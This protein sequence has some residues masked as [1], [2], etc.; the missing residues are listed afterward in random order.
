[1]L[2]WIVA[3]T[4]TFLFQVSNVYVA[5]IVFVLWIIMRLF[6]R[7]TSYSFNQKE[8]YIFIFY[9]GWI[10]FSMLIFWLQYHYFEIRNIVQFLYNFQY[11]FLLVDGTLDKNK[12][13]RA[14]YYCSY[15]L[16]GTIIGLWIFKTDMMSIST[17]V[18]HHREW[19]E[20]YIGGWPNSTVLPLVFGVYMEMSAFMKDKRITGMVRLCI[21]LFA[22][23]LCT[24]R[25][26]YVGAALVIV[27]FLFSVGQDTKKWKKVFKYALSIVIVAIVSVGVISI[28][29]TEEM[30]GRMLMVADRMEIVKDA[31]VYIGNRPISGY[32]GNTVDVVYKVVARTTTGINWGHTHNTILELLIRHGI[33]GMLTFVLFIFGISKHLVSKE[34]KAMY[35]ILWI[36][37]LFQIYYKDFVF[38][39]LLY[40]L[41]PQKGIKSSM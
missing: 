16:A 35:W 25:T 2:Y 9:I 10:L 15:L 34:E 28:I 26:G 7:K 38:L 27:Y 36:L 13:K 23:L 5:N 11:I 37:S 18:V 20:G 41:V 24:S 3:F 40:S 17:L 21:L 19:A 32:G 6:I 29:T 12:L 8:L 39:L 33:V 22:L 4:A 1:M 14:M 31:L 30:R